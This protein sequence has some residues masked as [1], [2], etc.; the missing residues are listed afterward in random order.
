MTPPGPTQGKTDPGARRGARGRAACFALGALVLAVPAARAQ[1]PRARVGEFE[2]RGFDL[3]SDG[4]WRRNS[5]RVVAERTALLRSGAFAR[6]NGTDAFRPAVSGRFFIPVIPI[7]FRDASAP[8]ASALYQELFFTQVPVGR[9]WSV[10]TY[11]QAQ[12]RGLVTLDGVVFDWVLLDS[13]A[14]YY[15][16]GC[17]G[18]GVVAP[19]PVRPRSRMADLLIGALD[20]IA[21]GPGGDTVWNAFDNDGPDGISNS[22]DDDGIVDLV[23]FLQAKIDGACGT[24][25]L[26]AH[27]FR[28][29]GWNSG[30]AYTTRTPRRGSNGLPLPGQ[31]LKVNSYTL[32]SGQGGNS[33]CTAGQIMPIGTVAHETGHAFGLPDLYDTDAGSGTSGIGEWG[34]M[35][36]GNYARPYSPS[37][38]DAWSLTQLGWAVVDTV[39]NNRMTT[40]A[41]IQSSDTVFFAPTST[42]G[43]FLL[44]EN[45]Q[46]EASDTAMMNPAYVRAK[47][48]GLLIWLVDQARID[49]GT[50]SNTV[51]T[52]AHQGLALMQADGLNQLRS[53]VSGIK[54]RGDAG[55]PFPGSAL[56]RDFGLAGPAP[57]VNWDGSPLGLRIDAI[58]ALGDGRI[59]FRY[60]RRAAT[61]IASQTTLAKVRVN[62]HVGSSISEIFAPGD[63]LSLSTD[64]VQVTGDGR[65]AARF[66]RWSNGGA[67]VQSVTARAG[68][69]D[70]IRAEF[71]LAHRLRALANGPGTV[72]LSIAGDATAGVFVDAGSVVR[73][74][75]VA[76]AGVEFL[77]WRGDTTSTLST[78]DLRLNRPFDVTADFVAVAAVDSK[79]AASALL[80]GPSLDPAVT[81]YLDAIGNRNGT[82]DVGDYLAWLRRTGQPVPAALLR[83]GMHAGV[84]R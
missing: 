13:A 76:P 70:T 27:R 67:Q 7:A 84:I 83:S 74:S 26:W 64:S 61:L 24:D 11:Y 21:K 14:A 71:A 23:T 19:C 63:T 65:S 55:D 33:A 8:F 17:N 80:G 56:N 47:G 48:P 37:S 57:S 79:A 41:S 82:F 73:L 54:N 9:P 53:S 38:F 15:E 35:G 32:Q 20:S 44:L 51:N 34:L 49:A 69:P 29:S 72:S 31:F 3:P 25:G 42:A 36:A 5:E 18:I 58:T 60:V 59:R 75:A 46:R 10:R 22:G 52:G 4:G 43:L 62:G 45:R 77:G 2:V 68:A 28:I 66:L 78:L 40:T 1:W 16:D 50:G 6:L 39:P 12:S 30:F 81:R